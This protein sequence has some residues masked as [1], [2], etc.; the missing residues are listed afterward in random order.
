MQDKSED[1]REGY[2][3]GYQAGREEGV[4]IGRAQGGYFAGVTDICNMMRERRE[5]LTGQ[6]K[7]QALVDAITSLTIDSKPQGKGRNG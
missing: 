7:G 5:A 6:L 3:A 2:G 1:Y 4:L